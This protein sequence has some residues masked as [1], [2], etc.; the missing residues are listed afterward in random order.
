MDDLEKRRYWE[1]K[2]EALITILELLKRMWT[3]RKTDCGLNE[4][5]HTI[6]E[7]S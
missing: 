6:R 1:M 3:C 2:E 4:L 7:G 5:Q